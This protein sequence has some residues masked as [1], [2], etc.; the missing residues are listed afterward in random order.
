VHDVCSR[1]V[2]VNVVFGLK[3]AD[4]TIVGGSI[5]ILSNVVEEEIGA[6]V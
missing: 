4:G 5:A 6:G 3:V 2:G 1:A